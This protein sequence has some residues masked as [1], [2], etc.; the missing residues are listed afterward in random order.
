MSTDTPI[1]ES[2]EPLTVINDDGTAPLPGQKPVGN[3]TTIY[4]SLKGM[5]AFIFNRRNRARNRG[6]IEKAQR[7]RKSLRI[8][9]NAYKRQMAQE[10]HSDLPDV[11]LDPR[12]RHE[13]AVGKPLFRGAKE[14]GRDARHTDRLTEAC[15][16][17]RIRNRI[18]ERD[19]VAVSALPEGTEDER[20]AKFQ[21]Y[22]DA[23]KKLYNLTDAEIEPYKAPFFQTSDQIR[24]Q[25]EAQIAAFNATLELARLEKEKAGASHD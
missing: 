15:I 18:W 17:Q 21:A 6:K 7:N 23:D 11:R 9:R 16:A 12:D 19:L 25:A 4:G 3:S 5:P 1:I 20:W 13:F 22:S 14:A 10:G 8:L 2:T 24:A